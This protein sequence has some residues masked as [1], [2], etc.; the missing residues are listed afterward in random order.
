[1]D[2]MS[3]RSDIGHGTSTTSYPASPWRL[4]G[5]M[6]ASFFA[7]APADIPHLGRAIPPHH[8]TV[9]LGGNAV[10][11]LA[12]A[13]YGAGGDLS[14]NELLVA[15]LA[16]RGLRP[17]ATVTQIWVDSPASQ[18]GGRALWAIPKDLATTRSTSTGRASAHPVERTEFH[19]P[20]APIVRLD[21]RPGR[22]LAPTRVA[23]PIPTAQREGAVTVTAQN[24]VT[25]TV[26]TASAHWEVAARGPLGWLTSHRP[27]GSFTLTNADLTFGARVDRST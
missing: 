11:G 8:R 12:V 18:A 26:R 15:V 13:Q 3:A 10:V 22:R 23:G 27:L 16:R 20:G 14:Y 21:R 2:C 7:V 6:T 9:L 19:L 4:T 25:A 5:S 17:R 24:T 1:M